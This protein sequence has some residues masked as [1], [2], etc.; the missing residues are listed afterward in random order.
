MP[1][2]NEQSV[3]HLCVNRN[4]IVIVLNDAQSFNENLAPVK[5]SDRWGY[6]NKNNE[7]VI[8]FKYD[9][10]TI[11]RNGLAYAWI[12]SN[13]Y[14]VEGYITKAGNFIWYKEKH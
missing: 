3:S 2:T 13:D 1:F 4:K 12:N 11:F 6:I 10:C 9:S 7:V 8:D 5:S 14:M